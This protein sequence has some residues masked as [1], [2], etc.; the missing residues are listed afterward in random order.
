MATTVRALGPLS[1][2]K[3][4]IS[5]LSLSPSRHSDLLSCLPLPLRKKKQLL[6][7]FLAVPGLSYSAWN[8]RLLHTVS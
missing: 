1:S 7:G 6:F 3:S 2:S 4:A 8:R 5:G